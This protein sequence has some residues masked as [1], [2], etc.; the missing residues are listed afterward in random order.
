MMSTYGRYPVAFERGEGCRLW[1]TQDKEYL[2]FLSGIGVNNLGHCHPRVV[3]AIRH[4]AG[5][6]THTSN[7][8][9]IP[10]QEKLAEKLTATC[11]ADRAFFSNSGAEANEAAIKLARKYMKDSGQPGRYEIITATDSFHGRTLA[12]LTATGQEKVQFGFEPLM[13]GFRYVPYNDLEAAERAISGYTAAIMVEPIQG[14]SGVRVPDE[15]YLSGLRKLCD[16]KGILLILDEVQ[17]GMGRTGAMWSHQRSGVEP[18]IMTSSK[19]LAAGVPMGAC[20]AREEVAS[21]FSPG[22]HGSTFGGNP[23]SSAAALAVLEVMGEAD[24]LP[25]VRARGQ[26][27]YQ[28]LCNLSDNQSLIKEV[29]G[30]GLMAAVE[31]NCPAE[32]VVSICMSRGLL[33]NVCMGTTLRLLPPLVVSEAE[34]DQAVATIGEVMNDLF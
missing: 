32:E 28:A 23:L 27:L 13:P 1:D 15:N 3:E 21:A 25:T 9:R 18:D 33:I 17:T 8:Y 34:I 6:L 4:Q 30:A 24:F 12:T 31:L 14:E 22:T 29:R 20:L 11:F 10:L 16:D 19:A 7:L 5:V 2:D 26:Y